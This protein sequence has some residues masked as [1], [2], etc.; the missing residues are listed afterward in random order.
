MSFVF[1][2]PTQAPAPPAPAASKK[3]K[4][5]VMSQAEVS[6]Y[7]RSEMT[8][9]SLAKATRE[10]L[11][12]L[13]KCHLRFPVGERPAPR[14]R[15]KRP[16]LSGEANRKRRLTRWKTQNALLKNCLKSCKDKWYKAATD[17][18]GD[19]NRNKTVPDILRH[20]LSML[21]KQ[22]VKKKSVKK[23]G[24]RKTKRKTKKGGKRKTR[25]KKSR[26]RTRV[27]S[28]GQTGCDTINDCPSECL[29]A[30][31][32]WKCEKKEH[33]EGKFCYQEETKSRDDYEVPHTYF[34]RTRRRRRPVPFIL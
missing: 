33:D 18:I 30:G 17:L 26:R 7:V 22:P 2:P 19:A 20:I 8:Q 5:P 23:K 32:H 21:V 14:N 15:K 12:C 31:N 29:L 27:K 3:R 9:G 6:S 24:G 10:Y 16:T 25:R 11:S 4:P 28:G 13:D 34:P 1:T